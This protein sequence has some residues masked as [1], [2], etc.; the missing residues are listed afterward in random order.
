MRLIIPLLL[1]TVSLLPAATEDEIRKAEKDWTVAV[2]GLD[3]AA[4]G[5][6]LGE[7]LIYAHS[8][9]NIETKKE[10][11]ARLHSGAQKYDAIEL[12][13][14]NV[15]MYGGSAVSHSKARMTGKS[16]GNP[17]NDRLMIMHFWIKQGTVW[18]LVAH[19][20]TKLP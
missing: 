1:T 9:G 11:L 19:Q 3:Y 7:R 15:E 8:T 16:N 14:T 10:Y 5:H 12:E 2:T 6:I 18:R 17:F 20:T 4:L 13:S